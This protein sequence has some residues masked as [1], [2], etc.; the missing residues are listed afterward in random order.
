MSGN[1]HLGQF[2]RVDAAAKPQEFVSL[3]DRL[4]LQAG[5]RKQRTYDLMKV[6]PGDC[7]LDVG[8]GTGADVTALAERVGPTGRATGVDLS[9][10]MIAEARQRAKGSGDWVTFEQADAH[11][12]PFEDGIFDACRCERVLEHVEQPERVV[13]EM[14]RVLRPGGRIVAYEPDWGTT[15]LDVPNLELTERLT[16]LFSRGVQ[17]GWIGRHLRWLFHDAD[18]ERV[19]ID[20]DV[21][22]ITDF[23]LGAQLMRFEQLSASALEAGIVTREELDAW[24]DAAE[25]ENER[26]RF[27]ASLTF[28]YAVGVKQSEG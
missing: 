25:R 21:W 20:A 14:V 10:T 7:V 1:E 2:S 18:L 9:E 4:L 6:S 5:E 27:L 26:D 22:T 8:C 24:V 15:T 13:R 28:F 3:L 16:S 23:K 11:T 19:E 17:N 12:L